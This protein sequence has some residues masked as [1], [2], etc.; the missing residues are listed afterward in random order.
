MEARTMPWSETLCFAPVLAA[1]PN[2]AAFIRPC[3]RYLTKCGSI[4]DFPT[5]LLQASG[6]CGQR[7]GI[8]TSGVRGV[9]YE[10]VQ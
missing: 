3:R 4:A 5:L 6:R 8:Q 9:A 10:R 7:N 1:W 2:E